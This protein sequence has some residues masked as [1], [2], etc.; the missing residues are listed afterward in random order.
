LFA[1]QAADIRPPA[2]ITEIAPDVDAGQVLGN[3]AQQDGALGWHQRFGRG[4]T[5]RT[6][7]GA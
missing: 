6:I 2:A 7:L 1:H 5:A 3:F 4:F